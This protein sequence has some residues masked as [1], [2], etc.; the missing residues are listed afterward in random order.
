MADYDEVIPPG[1]EGKINVKLV[2]KKLSPGR[3]K[4]SFTVVSN[5][6]ELSKTV[7]YVSGTVKTI[8]Q[9]SKP[10]SI[11]GFRDEELADET[12]VTVTV[13]NPVD[14]TGYHWEK[15]GGRGE[16]GELL[17]HAVDV[18]ITAIEK[19]RKYR[20]AARLTKAI[21][22]KQYFSHLYLETDS[23]E[24]AQKQLS[25]NLH[26]MEDVQ[27]HPN[28]V[29]MQE[30]VIPE[31][32]SKSFEKVVSVVAARGDSLR[33]LELVPSDETITYSIREVKP[34]QAYQCRFQIRPPTQPG[35]YSATLTFRTNYRGYE[36]IVVPIRGAVRV[37]QDR[38]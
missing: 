8:L 26:V 1:Q 5:D 27:A 25:F 35:M 28:M 36:K 4:K 32:T 15:S 20:V 19:G 2:G 22:P 21:P 33:I 30:M 23:K 24:L 6:P 37:S 12:I 13:D 17:D 10:L 3:F 29:Y 16:V 11:S 38:R 14:I 7:L 18:K 34:G 9:I 31:G